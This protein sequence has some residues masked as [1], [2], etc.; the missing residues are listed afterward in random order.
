MNN[1]AAIRLVILGGGKGGTALLELF[2][3]L[4]GVT[5]VG[6]ADINPAAPAV[7]YA[8][9]LHIPFFSDPIEAIR[10]PGIDLI[11]NV[12]NDPALDHLIQEYKHPE[13]EVL[14]GAASKL[15]WQ[16]VQQEAQTQVQLLQA[17][18][19]ASMG[20]FAAGIAHDINNPLYVIQG[21]AENILEE[22]N[23]DVIHEQAKS[24]LDA[25]KRIQAIC[26][27]ITQY[28]RASVAIDATPVELHTKIEE[29]LKIARYATTLQDLTIVRN[30]N[31]PLE[32]MAKPQEIL[33]VFVNLLTNAIQAM[34]GRGTLTI[35]TWK[36]KQWAKVAIRDTGCGIPPEH[37]DKIFEPFFT[38]KPP[39]IGTGLGLHNVRW[40]VKKYFG[41]ITVDSQ[42]GKGTTF[43]L[44]FPL[45]GTH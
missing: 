26:L 27:N 40:I 4:S 16:L 13:T 23:L 11:I 37:L 21:F 10:Q 8:E 19:L 35:T 6:L 39:G 17:E 25:A 28:A 32:I 31:G 43:T 45:I 34:N 5:V 7:S 24:I 18:K 38:T 2:S 15:L 12:T 20:T 9:Q 14:S 33:Q 36:E 3:H 22:T 41:H 44:E 42:V 30:Y 29:A 1:H